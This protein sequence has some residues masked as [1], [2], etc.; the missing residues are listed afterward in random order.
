[1]V[2]AVYVTAFGP[3]D[4]LQLTEAPLPEPG[5]GRVRIKVAATTV[6][7]AD[8]Q[9]RRAPYQPPRTPPFI[10]GLEAA[11]TIDQLGPGVQGLEVGQRVT[12]H[13]EGG[14]YAEYA[15][16][17]AV[18]VFPIPESLD[19]ER[20][21]TVPSVGTTALNLLTLAGRLQPG[22]AVLI[23]AAAGGVGS[24]AV[25]LARHLGAA[26]IIGTVGNAEKAKLVLELGAD[27]AINYREED[28]AE[29][30]R[31]VT[32][33]SGADV[34]LDGVGADTFAASVASLAPWGRLVAYGM[35]SG[36]PPPVAF[37]PIYGENKAIVGYSTGGHRRTRPEALRAPGLAALKLLI[38]GR[39]KPIIG[40]RFP[41]AQAAE[42]HR[43][44]EDRESIGKVVLLP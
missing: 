22:E 3:P 17:R 23:H 21:A 16:A 43:M 4:V 33:G 5:P 30:V 44:I 42:A 26:L 19:W 9:A 15:L 13:I 20:A 41:L 24:T 27:V 37:G 11:G 14:S 32:G 8:V 7:F 40:A 1:L 29:R 35:A 28:V 36:P 38:Q 25:Q 39:W 12:A 31:A 10:P 34:V 6:N 2:K 18:E